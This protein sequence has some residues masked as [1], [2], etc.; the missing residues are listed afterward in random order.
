MNL[1]IHPYHNNL[2]NTG[3]FLMLDVEARAEDRGHDGVGATGGKR[4]SVGPVIVW[5]RKNIIL[6]STIKF[7]VFEHIRGTQVS[8][9]TQWN[10]G[11]GVTF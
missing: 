3:V 10:F 9:G 8:H 7:P 4:I 2:T 11:I 1:G 5:Y 6:R